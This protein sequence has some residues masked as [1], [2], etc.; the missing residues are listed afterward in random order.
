MA[1]TRLT[2]NLAN[3]YSARPILVQIYRC[4]RH[5]IIGLNTSDGGGLPGVGNTRLDQFDGACIVRSLLAAPGRSTAD[6]REHLPEV[7]LRY[8]GDLERHVRWLRRGIYAA[9]ILLQVRQEEVAFEPTSIGG[10]EVDQ[11]IKVM[12]IIINRPQISS[13]AAEDLAKCRFPSWASFGYA[14]MTQEILFAIGTS[15]LEQL[16]RLQS[17]FAL[18]MAGETRKYSPEY[19]HEQIVKLIQ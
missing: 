14:P 8:P 9:T 18:Q 10:A 5:A 19:V 12:W 13:W 6:V 15:G 11:W 17:D 3:G 4:R 7:A 2:M 1:G 16:E